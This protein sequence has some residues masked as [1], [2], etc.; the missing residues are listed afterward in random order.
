MRY[1]HSCYGNLFICRIIKRVQKRARVQ[2][3]DFLLLPV[4]GT[5]S[6]TLNANWETLVIAIYAQQIRNKIEFRDII[7]LILHP[8]SLIEST[9]FYTIRQMKIEIIKPD[10]VNVNR[11]SIICEIND[12]IIMEWSVFT[13]TKHMPI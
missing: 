12:N 13:L 8:I 10:N 2:N 9:K 6:Y 5:L 3:L 11:R 4:K 1:H 7:F